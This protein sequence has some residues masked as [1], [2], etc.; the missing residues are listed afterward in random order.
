M[1]AGELYK[2][3]LHMFTAKVI[4]QL[5][6]EYTKRG[7]AFFHVSGAGHEGSAVL[8]QF[9]APADYLHCHYRDKALMLARGITPKMFF[10][11]LFC[12]DA[13]HSRGRQMS[14]HMSAPELNILSLVGPV[15]NSALQAAGAAAEIKDNPGAPIVLCSLGDGMTQEGEVLEAIAHAV[16]AELPVLFLIEDNGF[17]IST[18]TGCNTFFHCP[19]GASDQ[20]Y[21]L[22]ITRVNG[23]KPESLSA[24]FQNVVEKMRTN[25]MPAIVVMETDRL[26]SHTNADDHTVYRG[27]DEIT[28]VQQTGDPV[29]NLRNWLVD[30]GIDEKQIQDDED[31][32]RKTLR[33]DAKISQLSKEPSPVFTAKAELPADLEDKAIEYRG[34]DKDRSVTMIEALRTVLDTELEKNKTL[35]LFG[36][37][38]ADPKGDV[39]GVTRG[40]SSKYPGRVENSPL[41][42]ATIAGVT[43]GRA[44]AG[45]QPIGFIQFADFLPIAFNQIISEMGSMYWRTD[46]G[47]TCPAILMITSG[48]YKPG[49]GPFHASSLESIAVHT[50]GVDVFMPS[51]AADAAG[52]L[53]AALKSKRP[54][55]FFYPKNLLNEKRTATSKDIEKQIVPIGSARIVTQGDDITLAGWGNT[56]GLCEKA[57]SALQEAGILAEVIDMR[58]LSPLD[59]DT[60]IQSCRKTG[61]LI[62]SHEDNI[63]CGVGSELAALVAESGVNA[64]ISRVARGDTYVPCNFANQLEVLPSYKRLLEESLRMLGGSVTW[65]KQD[66][67]SSGI[68]KIEAIGSSPSDETIIII[69]WKVKPGDEIS[70]G[71]VLADLEADKAAIELQAS[72][73]GT[74]EEIFHPDG[75]VVD[76]GTPIAS[77]RTI[78]E[79]S[80]KPVTSEN[81]GTPVISIT[82]PEKPSSNAVTAVDDADRSRVAVIAGVTGKTGSRLVTNQEISALCSAWEPKDIVKRTGIQT[83]YWVENGESALS[84]AVDVSKELLAQQQIRPQEIDCIICATGTPESITPSMACRIQYAVSNDSDLECQAYDINAACSGYIYGLQA[85]YD[86][87]RSNPDA[88]VLLVTTETLSCK[89]DASDPGTAPIFGDA[90]TATLVLGKNHQ[91]RG[92]WWI[93]RPVTSAKGEDGSS[94]FVPLL[95]ENTVKM[96]GTKVFLE[97]VAAMRKMLITACENSEITPDQLDLVVPHQANQR[98]IN[99]VRQKLKAPKEKVYSNIANLGNTSSSSIPMCLKD[100]LPPQGRYCGLTAFGGGF[101]YGAAVLE[102][103][104]TGETD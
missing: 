90:A 99:A 94:L 96:E 102:K 95:N 83:R 87:C 75:D 23:R 62:I 32:L 67:E 103:V 15:G 84:L 7:E 79:V 3:Y 89:L 19:S 34:T 68:Q 25:R 30:N 28:A 97:A 100:I 81:P 80:L 44:L 104:E 58:S 26:T 77:V 82:K 52:L 8:N 6:L 65:E 24:P 63:S 37:D 55:L 85:A 50:P 61:H 16:R 91:A 40:L 70:E 49:L 21:S 78:G 92:K 39:F 47:W 46:G 18:R 27:S 86:V 41:S 13:S 93:H 71:D 98:I 66:E 53:H 45:G 56:V 11:S 9:L 20:F 59:A 5:E 88:K 33:E 2:S 10:H 54:T 4:D 43:V 38:I 64:K 72:V 60:V 69:E 1:N 12:K 29:A 74:V 101:T 22:P 76:V 57:A 14:A 17:A 73:S 48:G 36:E 42:E 51:T 35:S 31:S